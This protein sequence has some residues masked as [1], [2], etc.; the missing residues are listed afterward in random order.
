VR[1]NRASE[2][3]EYTDNQNPHTY[4]AKSFK[5]HKT[6]KKRKKRSGSTFRRSLQTSINIGKPQYANITKKSEK[7]TQKEKN[8]ENK[9]HSCN[10][11]PLRY[12]VIAI[13][14][15]KPRIA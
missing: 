10:F 11:F 2:E 7:N 4:G 5:N 6:N 13:I 3:K 15:I 14:L 8:V 9:Y 1:S 12:L